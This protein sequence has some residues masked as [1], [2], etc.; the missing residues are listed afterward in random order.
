MTG[1]VVGVAKRSGDG[2]GN[3][4]GVTGRYR[5]LSIDGDN[6]LMDVVAGKDMGMADVV[7]F[8]G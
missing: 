6:T 8:V 1:A 5:L 4:P 7:V 3:G 2:R